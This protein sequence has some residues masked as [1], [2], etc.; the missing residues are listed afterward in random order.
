MSDQA[1]LLWWAGRSEEEYIMATGDCGPF[2][3]MAMLHSELLAVVALVRA[4]SL[5][6][7]IESGRYRGD[8]AD[9]LSRFG[10]RVE[11][12]ELERG[13][14]DDREARERLRGR[15]DLTL[16]Y[17]SGTDLVPPMVTPK[18]IVLIDGPKDHEQISLMETC[19]ERGAA[20]VAMHD[21]AKHKLGGRLLA[22]TGLP[23]VTT[24]DPEYVDRF[25]HM[26]DKCW[27]A[28]RG[29]RI[30]PAPYTWH[31]GRRVESYAATLSIVV[32]PEL[33]GSLRPA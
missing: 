2:N 5:D 7:I 16:H 14:D 20:A 6:H 25:R 9:A 8:S 24:S 21:M 23:F 4:L 22:E 13:T 29:N 1:G 12:V 31:R 30:M 27:E 28:L 18:S 17:G 11:S 26:D 3:P 15:K 10:C 19:L 33:R 32:A